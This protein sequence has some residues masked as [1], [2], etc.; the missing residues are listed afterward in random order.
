MLGFRSL[1]WI[2]PGEDM[3]SALVADAPTLEFCWSR[4]V[5]DAETQPLESFDAI[6][7][8]APGEGPAL[9][10]LEQLRRQTPL[11]PVLVRVNSADVPSRE[12]P[13]PL[14]GR[15]SPGDNCQIAYRT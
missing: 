9:A 13:P 10:A 8:T 4:D 11:P 3:G 1:L 15:I 2:G 7:L 14:E 6:V 5:R 12:R